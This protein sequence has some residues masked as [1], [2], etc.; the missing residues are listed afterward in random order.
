MSEKNRIINKI[1]KKLMPNRA[2][3]SSKSAGDDTD[4]ST[5]G[6][7]GSNAVFDEKG[8]KVMDRYPNM[9]FYK[10][11]R[12]IDNPQ[13]RQDAEGN[14]V[15]LTK[16]ELR[17]LGLVDSWNAYS[18]RYND[19]DFEYGEGVVQKDGKWYWTDPAHGIIDDKTNKLLSHKDIPENY[20]YIGGYE[21]PAYYNFD[22]PETPKD[23]NIKKGNNMFSGYYEGDHQDTKFDYYDD[24]E[25]IDRRTPRE[26]NQPWREHHAERGNIGSVEDYPHL[27][28]NKD[29]SLS[30]EEWLSQY[31]ESNRAGRIVDRQFLP[32]S[33]REIYSREN[34]E[35]GE[36][37][38]FTRW[39]IGG[40]D[41]EGG[42]GGKERK[43]SKKR[44]VKIKKKMNKRQDRVYGNE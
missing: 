9:G 22:N 12:N 5:W 3:Y 42:I 39:S 33:D 34:P 35:T 20:P 30:K 8:N 1:K 17:R 6:E 37:E 4:N 28:R 27:D 15:E 19:S 23:I 31:T 40:N 36:L 41:G 11:S 24:T 25:F 44:Y 32:N 10:D 26:H 29:G 43:I 13:I 7:S 14:P 38:Y 2:T 21:R 18:K 16:D